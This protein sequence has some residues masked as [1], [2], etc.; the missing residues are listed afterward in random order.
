MPRGKKKVIPDRER[1]DQNVFPD[2]NSG[3]HIWA[4]GCDEDGY[5]RLTVGSKLDA[6]HRT[7]RA[8]RYIYQLE[9]GP[10][11]PGLVV[12]HKCDTRCC[13]NPDHLALGTHDDNQKDKAR[14]DRGVRGA[15]P[16][17]VTKIKRARSKPFMAQTILG[18]KLRYLGTF[19]TPDEASAAVEHAKNA[20][21]PEMP[22]GEARR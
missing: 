20:Y 4:G 2:P 13:V 22:R 12:M 11:P 21:I 19:A 3:C 8:H 10:I 14:K 1:F 18:G 15:W 9:K 5:G 6:T 7:V 17:G 16:R